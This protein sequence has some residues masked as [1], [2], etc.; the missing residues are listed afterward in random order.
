MSKNFVVCILILNV[1]FLLWERVLRSN[2]AFLAF[3]R[4][5]S[6]KW[7]LLV[8]D[9]LCSA[10]FVCCMSCIDNDDE[11]ISNHLDIFIF[12]DLL[13]DKQQTKLW[14]NILFFSCTTCFD[15]PALITCVIQLGRIHIHKKWKWILILDNNKKVKVKV[16]ANNQSPLKSF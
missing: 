8:K 9:R 6:M 11:A 13:L 5:A 15:R 3:S 12:P 10:I 14:L 2:V 7:F 1:Q 16:T 4:L